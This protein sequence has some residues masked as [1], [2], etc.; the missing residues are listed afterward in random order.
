MGAM[1]DVTNA[2][3]SHAIFDL[4][5][6]LLVRTTAWFTATALLVMLLRPL[7]RKLNVTVAYVSWLLLPLALPLSVLLHQLP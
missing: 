4:S 5:F 3:F 6:E 2:P 1:F 7:L